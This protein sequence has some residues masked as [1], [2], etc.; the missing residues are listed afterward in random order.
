L[1]ILS[2]FE[3]RIGRTVEGGFARMFRA[4]VQPAELARKV[5]REMDKSKVVGIGK[6]YAPTMYSI[7]LSPEDDA[8][9]GGFASTLAGELE[10]YLVAYARE[11]SYTLATRPYVRFLVD[12]DL[13]LGRFEVIGELLSPQEMERAI[14][15]EQEPEDQPL[16]AE[17]DRRPYDDAA[18]LG[19]PYA[20]APV[21]HPV[22]VPFP[23]TSAFP[24]AV[25]QP[26]DAE[27]AP[28]V[29]RRASVLLA[30]GDEHILVGER[31]NVGRL[32]SCDITIPDHNVS[33]EHAAF[34]REGDGW[35]IE[36]LGSTNGTF[37]NGQPVESARL[38]DGDTI[39]V[40]VT[41]L[42]YHERDA[43]GQGI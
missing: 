13:K 21:A 17:Q 28:P 9:I 35:A 15:A 40:G 33:R 32:A 1:S 4:P 22:A 42:A 5:G 26:G 10:T 11:H 37:L 7:L 20:P 38:R 3:D 43:I 23:P 36:D 14:G 6:V 25:Q 18:A 41:V 16:P 24:A 19:A 39:Q 29:P 12:D 31:V 27:A 2:D 30:T 8:R 34:V